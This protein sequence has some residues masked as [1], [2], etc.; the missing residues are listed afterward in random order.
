MTQKVTVTPEL[1]DMFRSVL[2]EGRENALTAR[3]IHKLIGVDD[4]Q[5]RALTETLRLEGV[6]ICSSNDGYYLPATVDEMRQ[7]YWRIASQ[8]EKMSRIAE[9]MEEHIMNADPSRSNL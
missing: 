6:F 7:T 3:E 4:R 1:L 9:L 8:A 2:K 5:C